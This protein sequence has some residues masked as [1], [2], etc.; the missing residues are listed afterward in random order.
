MSRESNI[1]YVLMPKSWKY[2]FLKRSDLDNLERSEYDVSIWTKIKNYFKNQISICVDI[3]NNI[4]LQNIWKKCKVYKN[5]KVQSLKII[6]VKFDPY[7]DLDKVLF[8]YREHKNYFYDF[9]LIE[10]K[11][12]SN[13]LLIAGY[14]AFFTGARVSEIFP[15]LIL[16]YLAINKNK[17]NICSKIP[18]H[19]KFLINF[20]EK[21]NYFSEGLKTF[22]KDDFI[23][24]KTSNNSLLLIKIFYEFGKYIN[25]ILN[26]NKNN[27][28]YENLHK[29][30]S[31][32]LEKYIKKESNQILILEIKSSMY[33][34]KKILNH[35]LFVIHDLYKFCIDKKYYLHEKR[36]YLKKIN[37]QNCD[38]SFNS[39]T[40]KYFKDSEKEMVRLITLYLHS[41]FEEISNKWKKLQYSYSYYLKYPNY[42]I[43]FYQIDK[44]IQKLNSIK[45]KNILNFI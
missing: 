25:K 9:P 12:N 19:C 33:F 38:W 26:K 21:K 5:Y 29:S 4:N 1:L 36:D 16:G 20:L 40:S 22:L 41:I 32:V 11:N 30:F 15:F 13:K 39:L 2:D 14:D 28:Y 43:Y 17:K 34:E 45:C 7:N 6:S 18:E 27:T 35:F 37:I 31:Q 8:I 10:V 23:Q 42:F 24:L 3:Q 44:L